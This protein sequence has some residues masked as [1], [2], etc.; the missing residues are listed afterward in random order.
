MSRFSKKKK[1]SFLLYF[2]CLQKLLLISTAAFKLKIKNLQ[3]AKMENK[4]QFYAFLS[5]LG[6]LLCLLVRNPMIILAISLFLFLALFYFRFGI[7]CKDFNN[8]LLAIIFW[9]HRFH[10]GK[11]F[12]L[13]LH[14]F[15]NFPLNSNLST[16]TCFCTWRERKILVIPA[17][18]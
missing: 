1:K 5:A 2:S 16:K 14:I 3:Q 6:I 15:G 11:W 9:L 13:L 12:S 18:R 17:E 4:K 10:K 8:S 7:F